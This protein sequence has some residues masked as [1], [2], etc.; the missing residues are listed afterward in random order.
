VTGRGAFTAVVDPVA[1]SGAATRVLALARALRESGAEVR[2]SYSRGTGH[3]TDLAA[4]AAAAGET[5]LAV[6]G[7]A[8]VGAVA[9]GVAGTGADL[10]VVAAG[11]GDDLARAVPA[12]ARVPEFAAALRTAP[13]WTVDVIDL[14]GRTVVGGVR[15]GGV[16]FGPG[17]YRLAALAVSAGSRP[18]R[19]DLT[20]DGEPVTFVGHAV[21][22]A[23]GPRC[24]GGMPIAP[25]ARLDDGLLHVVT[26]PALPRRRL[27]GVLAALRRGTHLDLPGIGCRPARRVTVDTDRPARAYADGAAVPAG[28]L[29]ATVRPG[30]LRL[31]RPHPGED[32]SC[33]TTWW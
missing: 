25:A 23:N 19:Y 16:R 9:A 33:G 12:P 7:D 13:T 29:T 24:G 15:F 30:A 26:V 6:G 8:L 18:V 2:V 14:A 28:P 10:G 21:V 11:R 32:G 22:V 20:I 27:P 31:I 4:A 3:A 17:A 5:V 1:G